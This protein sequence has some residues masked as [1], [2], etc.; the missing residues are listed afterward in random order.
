[1]SNLG[2]GTELSRVSAK[3]STAKNCG[4]YDLLHPGD[5]DCRPPEN[6][7]TLNCDLA[8]GKRLLSRAERRCQSLGS[9]HP[10]N[11]MTNLA[12]GPGDPISTA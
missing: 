1:M 6:P 12:P 8:V 2:A 11:T 7:E 10:A 3:I 4:R 5:V 9:H